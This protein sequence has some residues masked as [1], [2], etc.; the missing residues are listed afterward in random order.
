M[1]D[2][3]AAVF[4]APYGRGAKRERLAFLGVTD[5]DSR[6]TL[7]LQDVRQVF[8]R[9]L[10][11]SLEALRLSLSDLSSDTLKGCLDLVPTTDGGGRGDWRD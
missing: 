3:P 5:L 4:P 11:D 9:V 10:R 1:G 7:D 2:L 6:T 8:G